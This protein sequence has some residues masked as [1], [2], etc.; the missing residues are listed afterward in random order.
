M[1]TAEKIRS[2]LFFILKFVLALSVVWILFS[3]TRREVIDCFRSFDYR[4]LI[5]VFFFSFLP[6]FFTALRWR[7]LADVLKIS[8]GKAESFSLTMQG[9]FFSLV[10]PGGAIGGDVVKMAVVSRRTRSGSKMEGVFSVFMDRVAGMLALFLLTLLL[11]IPESAL[12]MKLRI[13]TLPCEPAVNMLLIAG[14]VLLCLAGIGAG[15][16]I[17]FHQYFFR[18][19]GISF[20]VRKC[21]EHSKGAVSRMTAAADLYAAHWKKLLCQVLLTVFFIHLAAVLPFF[22]LLAGLGVQIPVMCVITAVTIGNI[23][24]LIPLFPGGIGIRDLVTVTILCAGSLTAADAKTAQLMATA[25][26]LAVNLTGGLFFI[27]DP[28]R[29]KQN[30]QHKQEAKNEQ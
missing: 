22:F 23:A 27:F 17:F 8:L 20:L 2:L 29:K 6:V 13:G 7:S 11:L 9:N 12:L 4:Y 26:M 28:G 24:G 3:R 5:P 19:P 25:V 30:E 21:E 18:L 10:I 16:L 15:C 1:A 14:L